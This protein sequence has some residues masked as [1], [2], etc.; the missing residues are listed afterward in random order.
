[1]RTVNNRLKIWRASATLGA[2]A[3]AG[4]KSKIIFDEI[5]KA[6]AIEIG[7][8]SETSGDVQ[9]RIEI[10]LFAL[11]AAHLLTTLHH[12]STP[13]QDASQILRGVSIDNL[14]IAGLVSLGVRPGLNG[15]VVYPSVRVISRYYDGESFD[16]KLG[17]GRSWI[18]PNESGKADSIFVMLGHLASVRQ[19]DP[20]YLE[21][22]ATVANAV[23]LAAVD[24]RLNGKSL[25][26]NPLLAIDIAYDE[27]EQRRARKAQSRRSHRARFGTD[28]TAVQPV[29][30]Q[31][32]SGRF[33]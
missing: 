8:T 30:Q 29:V 20:H 3:H 16:M 19:S 11:H 7:F 12:E 9:K 13:R 27:V 2:F 1:V 28:N 14:S 5:S 31:P 23:G 15:R 21:V 33:V 10:E 32:P 25:R 4:V 22:L 6:A 18:A 26:R 24:G 17:G